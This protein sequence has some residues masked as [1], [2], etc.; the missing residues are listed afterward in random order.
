MKEREIKIESD[1]L[2]NEVKQLQNQ[3]QMKDSEIMTLK[4]QKDDIYSEEVQNLM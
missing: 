1:L 2:K 4:S 3:I